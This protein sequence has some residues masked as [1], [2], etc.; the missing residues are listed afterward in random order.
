MG[1][2]TQWTTHPA[3]DGNWNNVIVEQNTRPSFSGYDASTH[4][5]RVTSLSTFPSYL[6]DSVINFYLKLKFHRV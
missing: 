5:V 1:G 2:G 3:P 6:F 4:T